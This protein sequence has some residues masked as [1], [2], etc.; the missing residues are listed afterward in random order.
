M[1]LT[2]NYFGSWSCSSESVCSQV[3]KVTAQLL[4]WRSQ[5][6]EWFIDTT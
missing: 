2:W 6:V 5:D 3:V 1:N 4:L